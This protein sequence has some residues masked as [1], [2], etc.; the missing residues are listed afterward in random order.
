MKPGLLVKYYACILERRA[1]CNTCEKFIPIEIGNRFLL[2]QKGEKISS[3]SFLCRFHGFI[4]GTA[5]AVAA[6]QIRKFNPIC[7]LFFME[8]GVI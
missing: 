6:F 1:F 5:V 3:Q 8:D 2:L 4:D 7:V